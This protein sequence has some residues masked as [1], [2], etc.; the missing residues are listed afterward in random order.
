[1][2]RREGDN[3]R[4]QRDY[5]DFVIDNIPLS[6]RFGDLI[7]CVGW[8][9]PSENEKNV[10]RLLL[11]VSA[12]F[13]NNRRSLYVCPECGDLSC[14]AISVVIEETENQIV[15]RN[16]AFEYDYNDDITEYSKIGPYIFDKKNYERV[17]RNVL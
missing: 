17:L 2:K 1:L 3:N 10:R 14:G 5:L 12:D 6:E 9:L 16:F 8:G 4:T 11:E 13:L 7:S 15:W